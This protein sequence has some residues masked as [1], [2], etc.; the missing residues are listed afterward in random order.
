MEK[1]GQ[2]LKE[3]QRKKKYFRIHKKNYNKI[4]VTAAQNKWILVAADLKKKG[5]EAKKVIT[6]SRTG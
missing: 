5:G 3:N 1:S 4:E 6:K 2:I